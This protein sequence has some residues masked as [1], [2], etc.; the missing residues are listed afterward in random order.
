MF[1]SLNSFL[2]GLTCGNY[3]L[4]LQWWGKW[5]MESVF[6]T[7]ISHIFHRE[8]CEIEQS[9]KKNL[10]NSHFDV[11]WYQNEVC[12][13]T[14]FESTESHFSV[15]YTRSTAF[16]KALCGVWPECLWVSRVTITK[17]MAP[18]AAQI[19]DSPPTICNI[20]QGRG[21]WERLKHCTS[22]PI[23]YLILQRYCLR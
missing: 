21:Q 8:I 22:S 4:L 5:S 17:P 1:W 12:R 20:T 6:P 2:L 14:N 18:N 19:W 13:G 11:Y 15:L 9:E 23:L 10:K 7:E 16:F 3:I